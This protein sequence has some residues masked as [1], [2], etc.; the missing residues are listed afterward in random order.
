MRVGSNSP[1]RVK[2]QELASAAHVSVDTI[3]RTLSGRNTKLDMG[4]LFRLVAYL[5]K[6]GD[7]T[8]VA[9]CFGHLIQSPPAKSSDS[10]ITIESLKSGLIRLF[11]KNGANAPELNFWIDDRGRKLMAIPDHTNAVRLALNLPIDTDAIRYACVNLG[12]VRVSSTSIDYADRGASPEAL[13]QA[14]QHVLTIQSPR[15]QINGENKVTLDAYDLILRQ[16]ERETNLDASLAFRWRIERKSLDAIS[17]RTLAEFAA[18]ANNAE[19]L[20]EFALSPEFRDRT[21]I[22]RIDGTSVRS[23][24]AGKTLA[25]DRR[26]IIGQDVRDRKDRRYDHMVYDHV[27]ETVSDSQPI[28]RDMDISL[29]GK[30]AK[31]RRVAVREIPRKNSPKDQPQLVATC[32]ERISWEPFK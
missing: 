31:Y 30:R 17:D 14:A 11:E 10:D 5:E 23:I 19:N 8:I 3:S 20:F 12:W 6:I 32:I 9:E 28:F 1:V 25:V 2:L 4:L 22:F 13:L 7:K 29:D 21:A 26:S 18:H 27:F 16:A 24:W 15:I